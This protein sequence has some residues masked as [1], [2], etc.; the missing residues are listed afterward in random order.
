MKQKTKDLLVKVKSSTAIDKA[1]EEW[2]VKNAEVLAR[3]AK[4][5]K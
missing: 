3:I 1:V 2:V 5:G 4:S